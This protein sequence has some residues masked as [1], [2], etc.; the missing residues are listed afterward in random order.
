MVLLDRTNL[1]LLDLLQKDARASVIG[2]SRAV[3]RA[4]STVR[5]RI[6]ALEREG[7]LRG[8]RALVDAEKLGFHAR[9]LLRA[10]CD[11]RHVPEL[12]RALG[13]IPQVTGAMLTTGTKPLVVQVM[14]EDLP[15]LEEVL[16]TRLAPLG[17]EQIEAAL[18]VHRLVEQRPVPLTPAL[19]G[20]D[21]S[22]L[23]GRL[24][25][26]GASGLA[27]IQPRLNPVRWEGGTRGAAP[28]GF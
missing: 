9:A 17:L 6:S 22:E 13:A 26:A 10:D 12:A 1:N 20:H 28:G 24:A 21:A 27:P 19:E 23:A 8:Y 16:E 25:E 18:V 11:L 14:A 3:N 4:E 5:E 15:R 7:I 2:L